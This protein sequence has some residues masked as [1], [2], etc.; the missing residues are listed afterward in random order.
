MMDIVRMGI[1]CFLPIV[2]VG[3]AR[4]GGMGVRLKG[5]EVGWRRGAMEVR[6]GS[7]ES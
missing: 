1:I 5:V 2:R 4:R 3:R 6:A 7:E